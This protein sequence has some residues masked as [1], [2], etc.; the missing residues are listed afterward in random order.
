MIDIQIPLPYRKED[1]EFILNNY[2]NVT[3]TVT[4]MAKKFNVTNRTIQRLVKAHGLVRTVA[5]ANKV[6]AKLKDY[7]KHRVPDHLKVK[8]NILKRSIRYELISKHPFCST[9]GSR[10]QDGVR[11]EIDHIDNNP[12]NNNIDNLQVLCMFCNQGKK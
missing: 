7:S 4:A 10:P 9:C 11:L 3:M 1:V 2:K 6:T 5:E 8:R 12:S